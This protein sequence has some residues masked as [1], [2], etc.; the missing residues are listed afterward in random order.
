MFW[1][2]GCFNAGNWCEL[3]RAREF[4]TDSSSWTSGNWGSCPCSGCFCPVF[5]IPSYG[6]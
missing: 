4:M 2:S 6:N 1:D 3:G 5:C